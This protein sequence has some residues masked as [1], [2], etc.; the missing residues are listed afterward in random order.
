MRYIVLR[1]QSQAEGTIVIQALTSVQQRASGI[2]SQWIEIQEAKT[3]YLEPEKCELLSFDDK[4]QLLNDIES[5]GFDDTIG[6]VGVDTEFVS[7]A[8]SINA[9]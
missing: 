3:N 4:E 7:N 1:S 5:W 2:T 6:V 8:S 9:E